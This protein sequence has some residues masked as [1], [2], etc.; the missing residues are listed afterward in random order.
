MRGVA[1]AGLL[2]VALLGARA[3]PH[4]L[5]QRAAVYRA[6][7]VSGSPQRTHAWAASGTAAYVAAFAHALV[8]RVQGPPP[9]PKQHAHVVFR[10]ACPGAQFVPADQPHDGRDVKKN[11]DGTYTVTAADGHA[12]LNVTIQ[13]ATPAAT[14][15]IVATPVTEGRDRAVP[16]TFD[17]TSY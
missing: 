17:L 13:S 5:P 10:C 8:A 11:D 6:V 12:V 7:I 15:R 3:A 2:A 4:R 9:A 14:Y 1:A 16:V